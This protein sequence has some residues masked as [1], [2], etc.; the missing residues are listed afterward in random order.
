M[1]R[2]L[3]VFAAFGVFLPSFAESA[4]VFEPFAADGRTWLVM[5][6][7]SCS[8]DPWLSF[9]L[10]SYYVDGDTVIG[11]TRCSK[12]M[13]QRLVQGM[14]HA[15]YF[16]SFS[17]E[18]GRVF[19]YMPMQEEPEL[20]YDFSASVGDTVYLGSS[21]LPLAWRAAWKVEGCDTLYA[22]GRQLRRL[23]VRSLDCGVADV[24]VEGCGNH[25]MHCFDSSPTL[26]SCIDKGD[27]VVGGDD[28]SGPARPPGYLRLLAVGK[29]WNQAYNDKGR[30]SENYSFSYEILGDTLVG[31]VRCYRLFSRNAGRS[32]SLSPLGL[33]FEGGRRVFSP[34]ISILPD[35]LYDFS[36]AKVGGQMSGYQSC[37]VES[38]GVGSAFGHDV[39]RLGI[40]Y[41]QNGGEV[42]CWMEGIG[43]DGSLI[44][45]CTWTPGGLVKLVSCTIGGVTFTRDGFHLSEP[46]IPDMPSAPYR[47]MLCEGKIWN[48]KYK[49]YDRETCEYHTE[50]RVY[51]LCGDTIVGGKQCMRMFLV[52]NGVAEYHSAWREDGKKVYRTLP[53]EEEELLYDFGLESGCITPYSYLYGSTT[54]FLSRTEVICAG[55]HYFTR[56]VLIDECFNECGFW[57]DGIGGAKS[58]FEPE[59]SLPTNGVGLHLVSCVWPDGMMFSDL[60]FQSPAVDYSAIGED[61]TN[62]VLPH[63]KPTD[64]YDLQGRRVTGTPQ[65][66]IYIR[67]GRKYVK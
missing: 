60:D 46:P 51:T 31:G 13:H 22:E 61:V 62:E 64:T 7:G 39:L 44:H 34:F 20:C 43:S 37:H 18:G 17:E 4:D 16:C 32:G 24:W 65:R 63:T 14:P 47:P 53:E 28:I 10:S 41:S 50:D 42:G 54:A 40:G 25:V 12:V 67:N 48:Y 11:E 55:G 8:T 29:V 30:P 59:G 36:P 9:T 5:N 45:P 52:R 21:S 66:G 33:L 58:L 26:V 23:H 2:L 27:E 6:S 56:Y 35:L 57:V 49:W 19:K 3:L 15:T 38:V 1:L